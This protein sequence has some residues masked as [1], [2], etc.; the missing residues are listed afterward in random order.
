[1][2]KFLKILAI[3]IVILIIIG[4]VAFFVLKSWYE[5]SLKPVE[6]KSQIV[7]VE[8]T[9]NMSTDKISKLLEENKII[10]SQLSFKIYV[11][12]NK[13]KNLQA[14]KYE[15]EAGKD[16]VEKV[17]SKLSNGEVVR[18]TIKISFI[19]G[20]TLEDYAKIIAEKTNNTEQDVY[21]L[22]KNEEY[23]NSLIEKYWFLTDEIKSEDL[24]YPLEGYFKPDT[25]E[26]ENE[27]VDVKYIFNYVLNYTEKFLNQYKEKIENTNL[28]VHQILTLASVV[29]LEGKTDE[30]RSGIAG[31]F[32]NRINAKMSLGSDVTTYYA[33]HVKMGDSDLTKKQINTYNPYN[34]RGPNM[35]GKIP[36]GPIS[37]PSESAIKAV[38]NPQESDNYYFVSDK[39][40]KAYFTK[41]YAEHQKVTQDLKDKG[42]W[43]VY[44]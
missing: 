13:I 8:I 18:D 2:K 10:N 6:T 31:V 23:I 1:M 22:L 33:F 38:L 26:F 21:D 34:T 25:Y 3:L 32:F 20:K 7:Q 19:E 36:V 44:E 27:D 14:G 4:I 42:L 9:K 15:F 41:N 43:F 24:Y 11:K 35:E 30:D 39:T 37:N 5:K 29:E 12:L 40:G 28:T 16:N 17:V